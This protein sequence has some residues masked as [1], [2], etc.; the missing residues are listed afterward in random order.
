MRSAADVSLPH[1]AKTVVAAVMLATVVPAVA[2]D[3]TD[4]R[5]KAPIVQT[6]IVGPV[7]DGQRS[8]TGIV[9]ARVRSNLGFRVNGKVVER[10]VD[11]G[12]SVTKG[13]PLMQLDD[14]DLKLALRAKEDA[15]IS[16]KAAVSRTLTDEQRYDRLAAIGAASRQLYEQAKEAY[17]TAVARLDAAIAD[18]DFAR[19]EATYAVLRADADGIVTD[20]LAEPGQVVSAG[21]AVIKLARSG[22]REAS[23]NLP[24][25]VRPAIGSDG[26]ATVYGGRGEV[27][28]A[29]LRQLSNAA[30][31]ATRTFEARYVL[32]NADEIPLGS[33]VKVSI[34]VAADQSSINRV[35]VP[36]GAVWDDGSRTG[37]WQVTDKSTVSFR[38][39]KVFKLGEETAVVTGV[40]QGATVV[41]VGANLLN[42]GMSVRSSGKEV[43]SK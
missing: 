26:I 35:E 10:L 36:I 13:Q 4:P 19:N 14:I 15:V 31:P 7:T 24:E 8:F 39:V 3:A 42:D 33:T 23:V 43:A 28:A 41:A 27:I 18:V 30:D 16:A 21:Q 22:D 34:N 29:H 11:V 38:A 32:K 9:T 40:S 6:A 5:L 37:V 17:D 25:T 1:L 2:Q 20:T 12:Q